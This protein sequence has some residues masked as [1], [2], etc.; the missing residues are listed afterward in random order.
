MQNPIAIFDQSLGRVKHL[1]GL[2]ESI[3]KIFTEIVDISDLLRSQIVLVVSALDFYV[4]EVTRI[5]MIQCL[6]GLRSKSKAFL[7]F[8]ITAEA[9]LLD[10]DQRIVRFEQEVR[11]R[12]S[13]LSFQQPEKIADAFRLFSDENLWDLLSKDISEDAKDIKIQLKLIVERRNRIAHEGDLDPS[14][15]DQRWPISSTDVKDTVNF[16]EK[17]CHSMNKIFY[18]AVT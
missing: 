9:Y 15:P 3:G 13:F 2:H 1:G 16:I 6:T 12:H 14:Y 11:E 18:V 4:H 7:K 10:N 17:I 5:G 8:P